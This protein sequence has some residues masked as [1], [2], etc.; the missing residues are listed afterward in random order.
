MIKAFL[1][2]LFLTLTARASTVTLAWDPSPT[3]GVDYKVYAKANAEAYAAVVQTSGLTATVTFDQSKTNSWY[4]TARSW[5][6]NVESVPSNEVVYPPQQSLEI[7]LTAPTVSTNVVL[8]T[9]TLVVNAFVKNAGATD[10]SISSA[11]LN[12]IPP[13]WTTAGG[14]YITVATLGPTTIP[15]SNAVGLAGTWLVPTNQQTGIWS[16]YVSAVMALSGAHT[17]GPLTTFSVAAV[18]P[19]PT[20]PETPNY[21]RGTAVSRS[22]IRLDWNHPNVSAVLSTRIERKRGDGS[23]SLV[24][25]VSGTGTTW[26]DRN[27]SRRTDYW[28]RVQA[29]NANGVSDYSA[30]LYYRSR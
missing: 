28:Y 14:S 13:G 4:V 12:V 26:T 1:T 7:V 9:E 19:E 21:L 29:A 6:N 3:P 27:L 10:L 2:L 5:T 8:P 17:N 30:P 20:I 24:K 15:S 16:T 22:S 18:V 23:Y 25:T 11:A